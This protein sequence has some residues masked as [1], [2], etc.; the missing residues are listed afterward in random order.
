MLIKMMIRLTTS[1]SYFTLIGTCRNMNIH[2]GRGGDKLVVPDITD[3]KKIHNI[4]V[5]MPEKWIAAPF[6]E[7]MVLS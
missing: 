4:Y 6:Y 1:F 3:N 5:R 2:T 7:P